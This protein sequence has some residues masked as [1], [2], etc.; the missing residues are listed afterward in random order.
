MAQL[1][2]H[3]LRKQ[4]VPGS[5]PGTALHRV[6]FLLVYDDILLACDFYISFQVLFKVVFSNG[7]KLDVPGTFNVNF[8]SFLIFHELE[9]TD[10]S[11]PQQLPARGPPCLQ[12]LEFS[13]DSSCLFVMCQF[14]CMS[15]TTNLL[16]WNVRQKPKYKI[17]VIMFITHVS[18]LLR[19]DIEWFNFCQPALLDQQCLSIWPQPK[20]NLLIK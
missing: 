16:G 18:T 4:E 8:C 5:V 19:W 14:R 10:I 20:Y 1:V 9:S 12:L 2:A 7:S 17:C 13:C 15:S 3:S 6:F 11:I